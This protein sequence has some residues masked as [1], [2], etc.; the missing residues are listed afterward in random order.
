[1][2]SNISYKHTHLHISPAFWNDLIIYTKIERVTLHSTYHDIGILLRVDTQFT[3]I[4]I[5]T[6]Q[7]TLFDH[8]YFADEETEVWKCWDKRS[9]IQIQAVCLRDQVL[10]T[11]QYHP[12]PS[13]PSI[14][15]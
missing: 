12:W 4:L 2:E 7:S 8:S 11:M 13:K 9:G 3:L 15:E 10:T 6:L 5:A 1:M 14:K